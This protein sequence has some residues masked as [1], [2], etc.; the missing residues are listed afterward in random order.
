[1]NINVPES[2]PIGYVVLMNLFGGDP[3]EPAALTKFSDGDTK[4]LLVRTCF[5]MFPTENEAE[6]SVRDLQDG[7]NV[8]VGMQ[9]R[10]CAV[11][12]SNIAAPHKKEDYQ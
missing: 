7:K 9:A 6:Q 10:I 4:K 1:M 5:T 2:A 11:F 12:P 8:V 3:W